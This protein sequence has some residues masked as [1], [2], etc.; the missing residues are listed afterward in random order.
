MSVL[1]MSICPIK[2]TRKYDVAFQTLHTMSLAMSF[3]PVT[4]IHQPIRWLVFSSEERE[5]FSSTRIF[6][7]HNRTHDLNAFHLFIFISFVSI[8]SLSFSRDLPFRF[9]SPFSENLFSFYFCRKIQ[10]HLIEINRLL[11]KHHIYR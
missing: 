4:Q 3:P 11:R 5:H 8:L 1:L 10:C 2:I 7:I 9:C 6:F